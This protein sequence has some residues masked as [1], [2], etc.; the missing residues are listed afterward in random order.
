MF[1]VCLAKETFGIYAASLEHPGVTGK[2]G[3][4]VGGVGA[5]AFDFQTIAAN[6]LRI[7]SF[8]DVGFALFLTT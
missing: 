1:G 6:E 7:S 8:R 4:P 5:C 2:A 3:N